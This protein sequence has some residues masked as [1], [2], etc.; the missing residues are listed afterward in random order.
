[1]KPEGHDFSFSRRSNDLRTEP[2]LMNVDSFELIVS[3]GLCNKRRD[4][5]LLCFGYQCH[6]L[7]TRDGRDRRSQDCQMSYAMFSNFQNTWVLI[8]GVA[9]FRGDI[10]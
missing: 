5:P 7:R 8:S 3:L 9:F 1:M 10:P 2:T 4:V 6:H